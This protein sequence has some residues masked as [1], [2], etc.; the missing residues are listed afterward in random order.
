MPNPLVLPET[1]MLGDEQAFDAYYQICDLPDRALLESYF[2]TQDA[3]DYSEGMGIL[4][5]AEMI[6]AGLGK[7]SKAFPMADDPED[8]DIT[9][10]D[11]TPL[12]DEDL[13][14]L[15]AD[16]LQILLTHPESELMQIWTER[17]EARLWVSHVQS[18]LDVISVP[19]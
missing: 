15:A 3:P 12:I 17:K 19:A 18:L 13:R 2:L 7:P 1:Y 16:K 5:A 14:Q 6:A 4:V 9:P 10:A 8:Q 11:L